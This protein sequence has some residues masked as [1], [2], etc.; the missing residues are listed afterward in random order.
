M[1]PSIFIPLDFLALIIPAGGWLRHYATS[2]KV[3]G[4]IV[5]EVT[6]FFG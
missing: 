2:Q 6:G 1:A 4:L 5:D 3:A